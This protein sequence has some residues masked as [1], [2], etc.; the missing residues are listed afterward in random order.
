MVNPE[1]YAILRMGQSPTL[2]IETWSELSDSG[3]RECLAMAFVG[4]DNITDAIPESDWLRMFREAGQ[5]K[6]PEALP[7]EPDISAG[8]YRAATRA[9]R[10]GLSWTT[11]LKSAAVFGTAHLPRGC[12]P[13]R[14]PCA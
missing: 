3:R 14:G 11:D 5:F 6:H 7:S 2:L 8:I 12:V 4:T 10:L 9:R 13:V 1:D